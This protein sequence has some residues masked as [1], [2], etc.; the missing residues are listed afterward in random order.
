[1]ARQENVV[2]YCDIIESP[3]IM[4]VMEYSPLGDLSKYWVER[5]ERQELGVMLHQVSQALSYIHTQNVTHR[6]IKPGNILVASSAPFVAKLADFGLSSENIL[7]KTFCGS[8]LYLAPEGDAAQNNRAKAGA[9]HWYDSK[10]DIWAL[11][12][13]VLQYLCGLP[14]IQNDDQNWLRIHDHATGVAGALSK[15]T[16]KMLQLDPEDRPSALELVAEPELKA[17]KKMGEKSEALEGGGES[18]KLLPSK[19]LIG[20]ISEHALADVS[21]WREDGSKQ[22][23]CLTKRTPSKNPQS[24]RKGDIGV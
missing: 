20:E 13:I 3:D 1:M 2:R 19:R 22:P 16:Q 8:K 11:G 18:R 6:D 24:A 17:P 9:Y 12:V 7:S 21:K 23:Q 4:L 14:S 10:V 5:P 15:V